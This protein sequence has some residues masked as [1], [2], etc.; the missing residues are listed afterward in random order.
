MTIQRPILSD[1]LSHQPNALGQQQVPLLLPTA[2][3]RREVKLT[4]V[5]ASHVHGTLRR[6][7][8]PKIGAIRALAFDSKCFSAT[9][10]NV[11]YAVITRLG[12]QNASCT[13]TMFFRGRR[14]VRLGKT[15]CAPCARRAMSVAVTAS[16][17][18]AFQ[19]CGAGGSP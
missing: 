19:H 10:S 18:R 9:G 8:S 1:N 5:F 3:Q 14:A 17:T 4:R 13:L 15:T 12:T 16:P 11:Y 7:F 2:T 6:P